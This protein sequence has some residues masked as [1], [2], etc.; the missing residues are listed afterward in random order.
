MLKNSNFEKKEDNRIESRKSFNKRRKN[1]S[2]TLDFTYSIDDN[3]SKNYNKKASREVSNIEL[4]TISNHKNIEINFDT[5]TKNI[6]K[7][8]ATTSEK[9]FSNKISIPK[10]SLCNV[11][12]S[13]EVLTERFKTPPL[14]E[15]SN[16]PTDRSGRRLPTTDRSD[17]KKYNY[18]I[19]PVV[20]YPMINT[21][22]IMMNNNWYVLDEYVHD[23]RQLKKIHPGG[24]YLF[25][26]SNKKDFLKAHSLDDPYINRI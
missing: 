12:K 23:I 8:S 4:D 2:D 24:Q 15:R 5:S 26:I 11:N 14:T 20:N 3:V 6:T 17:R 18:E 7:F 19:A 16:K 1:I 21:P 9:N 22:D 13:P 10:I 25:M